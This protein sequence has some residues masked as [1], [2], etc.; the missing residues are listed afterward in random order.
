MYGEKSEEDKEEDTVRKA[1]NK[2]RQK[3]AIHQQMRN[4]R[5]KAA[6]HAEKATE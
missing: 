4:V 2:A 3:K 5:W 1:C 6:W